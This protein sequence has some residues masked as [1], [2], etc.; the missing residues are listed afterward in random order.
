MTIIPIYID[1]SKK[2]TGKQ[3]N[4]TAEL[5]AVIE[6]L[7][8]L[9]EE[10]NSNK[11]IIIC[12]DSEYVIKC[13]TTYGEKLEK[14]NW[15]T[16][17]GAEPPNVELVKYLY[18]IFKNYK[19][20]HLKH[21]AAHTDNADIFSLG[22]SKAD[23]LAN[24]SIG[25]SSCPYVTNSDNL[26]V[27]ISNNKKIYLLVDYK[28]KDYAKTL[29]AKWDPTKKSWYIYDNISEDNKQKIFEKFSKK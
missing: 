2:I 5:K 18:E 7:E 6:A 17:K 1:Y 16:L 13:C 10:I 21:I 4:N 11:Q 20:I 8:I 14:K 15:K 28:D 3:T 9:K 23:M 24:N 25:Y 22:N 27:K 12:T 29:G 26:I 19:N